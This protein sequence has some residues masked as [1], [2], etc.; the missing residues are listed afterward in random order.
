MD[1]QNPLLNEFY[2]KFKSSTV[3]SKMPEDDRIR[4]I[5][6]YQN[7]TTEQI[8]NAFNV[9]NKYDSELEEINKKNEEYNEELQNLA[10]QI[11][12][13]Y[14]KLKKETH[15]IQTEEEERESSKHADSLLKELENM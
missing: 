4:V 6:A 3:Y 8:K 9:I 13:L 15:R 10:E 12:T 7:A 14:T 1:T 2:E 11:N 5:E